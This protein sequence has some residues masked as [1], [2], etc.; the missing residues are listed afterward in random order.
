MRRRQAR[1]CLEA[2]P[3][4]IRSRFGRLPHRW[5]PKARCCRRRR[6][7]GRRAHWGGRCQR[8]G[9]PFGRT[10]TRRPFARAARPPNPWPPQ[11]RA[12]ARERAAAALAAAARAWEVAARATVVVM[13]RVAAERARVAVVKARVVAAWAV[14]AKAVWADRAA[15]TARTRTRPWPCAARSR[16]SR[17]LAGTRQSQTAGRHRRSAGRR[18][19]RWP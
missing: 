2:Q 6:A 17:C 7:V 16:H 13:V 11:S 10:S 3:A 9:R 8:R 14:A 18:S 5:C 15:A 19:S 1:G 4:A 12:A